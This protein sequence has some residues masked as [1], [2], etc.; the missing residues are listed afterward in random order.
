MKK[1]ELT[2]MGAWVHIYTKFNSS[3]VKKHLWF[4]AVKNNLCAAHI[5]SALSLYQKSAVKGRPNP[6]HC[7]EEDETLFS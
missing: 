6:S 7:P 3:L 1:Q 5:L 2:Y 4:D